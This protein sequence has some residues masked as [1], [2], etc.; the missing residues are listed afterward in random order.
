[1]DRSRLFPQDVFV[2]CY[3]ELMCVDSFDHMNVIQVLVLLS[4]CVCIHRDVC[5]ALYAICSLGGLRLCDL[6]VEDGQR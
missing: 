6:W 5:G 1:M 4:N 3:A 2:M